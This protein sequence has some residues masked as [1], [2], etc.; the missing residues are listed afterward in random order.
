MGIKGTGVDNIY[1]T[2]RHAENFSFLP[3]GKIKINVR[4]HSSEVCKRGLIQ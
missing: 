2:E 1:D 4:Y 3:I